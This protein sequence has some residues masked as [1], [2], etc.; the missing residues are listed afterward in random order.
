[1]KRR[2]TAFL[3][4]FVL[5]TLTGCAAEQGAA[6]NTESATLAPAISE[7][8]ELPQPP[9]KPYT[10]PET[11]TVNMEEEIGETAAAETEVPETEATE[12]ET[13][14]RI[15]ANTKVTRRTAKTTQATTTAKATTTAATTQ[16]VKA[17]DVPLYKNL[18]ATTIMKYT[19]GTKNFKPTQK[20]KSRILFDFTES[21]SYGIGMDG[22]AAYMRMCYGVT[23]YVDNNKHILYV[24]PYNDYPDEFKLTITKYVLETDTKSTDL[25]K[26][27]K[28][29]AIDI[30][31]YANGL[32]RV[33]VTFSSKKYGALY[34]YVND[35]KAYTCST[36]TMTDDEYN[37]FKAHRER[38]D[39]LVDLYDASPENSLDM[40]QLCYPVHE[41]LYKSYNA[42]CDVER[43]A[44]L[45][46]E[47][48]N[49]N[50]SDDAK[51][52]AFHEWMTENLA[53]DRYVVDTLGMV[54]RIYAY[55]DFTGKWHTY[56]TKVGTCVDFSNILV[57]MCREHG[58]PC[59]I[60]E[61][62]GH[63]WNIVYIN[64]NWMEMDLTLDITA[65][66]NGEDIT[67]IDK[68]ELPYNYYSFNPL[69]KIDLGDN[70][71][72]WINVEL[73]DYAIMSGQRSYYDASLLDG[74]VI[75]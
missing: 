28:T 13:T 25:E 51:V 19:Y 14:T 21:H 59:N 6:E 41:E 72:K 71:P 12:A 53:Y 75:S 26:N 74:S 35:G 24:T 16:E 60:I 32:Y 33:K 20:N 48:V 31:D 42:R 61:N 44:K 37:K 58:I 65:K 39:T 23:G 49:D 22:T 62:N 45:S 69:A 46:H 52:F 29:K 5:L 47:L 67:K 73:C 34:F 64:G 8:L 1:M 54:N 63:A 38:I 50:M 15:T 68:E 57:I 56:T 70:E 55:S 9:A 10:P 2:I 30:S 36:I 27:F 7:L 3:L 18:G 4:A 11:T 66:A 43:W 17:V 40:T